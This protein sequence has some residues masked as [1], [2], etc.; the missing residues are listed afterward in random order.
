MPHLLKHI[1]ILKGRTAST[2][3]ATDFSQEDLD[4]HDCDAGKNK[5]INIGGNFKIW[6]NM[7]TNY[8]KRI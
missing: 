3:A 7:K 4:M 8:L 6:G 1:C 5:K 2:L